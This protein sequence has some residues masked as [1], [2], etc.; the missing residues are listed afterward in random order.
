HR[1]VGVTALIL[2]GVAVL[3]GVP[4][5]V[6]LTAWRGI[7]FALAWVL[8]GA[9][10]MIAVLTGAEELRWRRTRYRASSDT[11]ELH[12]GILFLSRRRLA[13][14]RI[15]AVDTS[16]HPVMRVFGLTKLTIGTGEQGGGGTDTET[17]VLDPVTRE[18]G[19]RL[20][21]LLLNRDSSPG[22]DASADDTARLATWRLVW[23]RY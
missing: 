10:L 19:E 21:A 3:A 5:T 8:P 22:T 9:V 12:R 7:G 14:A 16:A 2:L 1:T 4:T 23:V 11:V 6:G 17:I 15:R 13:R 20:R 18:T